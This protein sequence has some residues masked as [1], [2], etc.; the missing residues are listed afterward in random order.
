M[1]SGFVII[2]LRR[3]RYVKIINQSAT[4]ASGMFVTLDTGLN[5]KEG[6]GK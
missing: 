4:Y 6:K 1:I 5:S 3:L 2:R